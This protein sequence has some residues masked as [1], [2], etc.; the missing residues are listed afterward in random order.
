MTNETRRAK[1]AVLR[2]SPETVL[3]D[4]EGLMELAGFRQALDPSATT[5]L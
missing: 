4:Y 1:V 3:Q 5:I 2:T